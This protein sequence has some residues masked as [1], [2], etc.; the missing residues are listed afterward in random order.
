LPERQ[1]HWLQYGNI[2]QP[3]PMAAGN[4]NLGDVSYRVRKYPKQNKLR[5]GAPNSWNRKG[6]RD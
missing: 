5:I 4:S 3:L 1:K 6:K 2:L